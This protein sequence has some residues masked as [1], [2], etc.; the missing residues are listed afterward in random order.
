MPRHDLDAVSLVAGVAFAGLALVSLLDQW[1]VLSARWLIPLLLI[2]VGI[3][4]L[5]ANRSSPRD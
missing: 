4:G 3:A 1:A 5:A 2:A